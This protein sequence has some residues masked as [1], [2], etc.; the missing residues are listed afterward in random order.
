MSLS[1]LLYFLSLSIALFS[2][3][4][5]GRSSS[6][7]LC[8]PPFLSLSISPPRS[9]RHASS[10]NPGAGQTGGNKRVGGVFRVNP[11][12][13]PRHVGRGRTIPSPPGDIK[14]REAETG[15]ES[16][17]SCPLSC[18]VPRPPP[19]VAVVRD[20]AGV[21]LHNEPP[22]RPGARER[23]RHPRGASRPLLAPECDRRARR[24][25]SRG[26]AAVIA[27]RPCCEQQYR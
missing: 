27:P 19:R 24:A 2:I 12:S 14:S 18:P 5:T 26:W 22:R 9:S 6:L 23:L 17:L 16:G 8:L 4:P 1:V 15:H 21:E 3:F 7:Y 25:F 20:A 11:S 13:P 10:S